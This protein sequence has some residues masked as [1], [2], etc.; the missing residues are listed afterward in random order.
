MAAACER[1]AT[2]EAAQ[3]EVGGSQNH[4]RHV[5]LRR[6]EGDAQAVREQ[7]RDDRAVVLHPRHHAQVGAGAL[8]RHALRQPRPQ[9]HHV[10]RVQAVHV[11]RVEVEELGGG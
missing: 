6:V 4:L 10:P 8:G 1:V 5:A 2:R 7:L 9:R 11:G 3:V